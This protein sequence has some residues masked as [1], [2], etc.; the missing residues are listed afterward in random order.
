LSRALR[1]VAVIAAGGLLTAATLALL[2]PQVGAV[3]SAHTA[4]PV[5][6][7]LD[8]LAQRSIV[9]AADGTDVLAALHREQ[10]R[11][12]VP[13]SDIP[14][15]VVGTVLAVED[16]GFYDH[17]GVDVRSMVRALFTNVQA[18]DVRQGGSTITQQLVKN[19][20]LDSR[21]DFSR[22]IKEAVLAVRL[23]GQLSKK[24][25][26]ERYL[27]TVYL[28]SGTYG[29]QAAAETY[30]GKDAKDLNQADAALLAGMIK[31]PVGY[32]PLRFPDAAAKRRREVVARLQR[33]GAVDD[34]GAAAILAT[35]LPTEAHSTLPKPDDYFVDE[36]VQRLL[37]DE[38]LGSTPT[39]RYNALFTGGLTITTTLDPGAQQKAMDAV[40]KTLPD[41]K[42]RFTA[43]LVSIEPSTGAVRALVGGPGFEQSKYNIATQGLGRQVGSAMKPFV[44]AAAIDEGISPK[45]TI[46]GAG[47]C[48]IPNPGGTPDP[49]EAE[50][51][52]GEAAGVESLYDATKHS[53]NCAYLRLGQVVGIPKVI[54]MAHKLGITADLP[55]IP[56]L[57]LGTG[58]IH[59]ID[60]ASAYATFAAEGVYREP[61]FVQQIKDRHG[62]VIYEHEDHPERAITTETAREVTDVLKGVVTGGTGTAAR[63]RDRRPAAGKTG[64]TAEHGDAWF[65]GYTPELSTAVWMGSPIGR[66]PM[67]GVGGVRRV[68]GGSF[69]ARI[70]QAFMGAELAGRPITQ[71][72]PPGFVGK[73][74]YLRMEG[75]TKPVRRRRVTTTVAPGETPTPTSTATTPT[76][77]G[78][79]TT[80]PPDT[81]A[82]PDT[83]G[84]P[85]KKH[86]PTTEPSTSGQTVGGA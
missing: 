54:A 16:K 35:P 5:A 42:G 71:F 65:V 29:V 43:A 9:L 56:S 25:I 40:A 45:S 78:P 59:P 22:K 11:K 73:G 79:V 49:Y 7:D 60:M 28:G 17:G 68:T 2:A 6:I 32:D 41:T 53:V 38:R 12:V 48:S 51:F 10:N 18:G 58:E 24:E 85:G 13:F 8:P 74:T 30:F 80:S 61:Y 70:W 69:P 77:A 47:K 20:L 46:N 27:N 76:T 1:F 14:A 34:A 4:K 64:T 26:L 55:A 50:N 21:Q 63:F 84:P 39:E 62:E 66:E 67:T 37:A 75:D 3:L 44:L 83:K 52:E 36:V 31:N 23:E 19:A 57:P 86:V 33:I 82:P 72:T 15:V 81:E